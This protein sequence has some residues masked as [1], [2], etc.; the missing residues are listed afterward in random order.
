L[1]VNF[2]KSK[3]FFHFTAKAHLRKRLIGTFGGW[4]NRF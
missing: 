2:D 3:G 4:I 1:F